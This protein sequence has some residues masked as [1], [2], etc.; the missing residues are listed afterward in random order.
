MAGNLKEL[1]HTSRFVQST[2][3]R[4]R[5]CYGN[6]S[7]H[8]VNPGDWYLAVKDGL[9]EKNYCV[10]CARR[11]I[12]QARLRVDGLSTRLEELTRGGSS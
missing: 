8:R 3:N 6:R 7:S 1:L 11:I 5:I 4:K 10:A 9:G 12:G 2:S